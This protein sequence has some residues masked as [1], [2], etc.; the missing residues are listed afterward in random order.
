MCIYLC[1]YICMFVCVSL[2]AY[3]SVFLRISMCIYVCVFIF[4][5]TSRFLS[6]NIYMCVFVCMYIRTYVCML[7][8]YLFV[9]VR[10]KFLPS[11]QK[12]GWSG[13][14][15]ES[16]VTQAFFST[17]FFPA[18]LTNGLEGEPV[19]LRPPEPRRRCASES[20]I[21]TSSSGSGVLGGNQ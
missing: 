7:R 3:I 4:L 16:V 14:G 2:Y 20:S 12:K 6:I 9:C 5:Y 15:A 19:S 17:V 18:G 21:S 13:D 1:V 11:F 8:M 10:K